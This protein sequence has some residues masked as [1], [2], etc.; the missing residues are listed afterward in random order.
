MIEVVGEPCL[1]T[2]ADEGIA[3]GIPFDDGA[4]EHHTA[5]EEGSEAYTHLV[6]DDAS[7]DKE[8]DRMKHVR[9]TN[10]NM[11]PVFLAYPD[12]KELNEL[13]S[14]YA[15]QEPVYDFIA[16]IDGFG[17]KFWIISNGD[18]KKLITE[19]FAQMS[20]LYIADGHHRSA[21][22]ALVGAEKTISSSTV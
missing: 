19:R 2:T 1:K 9:T 4:D 18:D 10:A 20:S 16:P 17:H 12:D 21:A 5:R 22:A 8:E 7:K 14:R 6:E 11:E 13:I 3:H 15:A